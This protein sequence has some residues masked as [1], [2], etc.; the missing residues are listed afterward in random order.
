[1]SDEILQG[2]FPEI[3]DF[4]LQ[5]VQPTGETGKVVYLRLHLLTPDDRSADSE[6]VAGLALAKR[7]GQSLS[8]L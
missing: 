7:L 5:L 6:C 3:T 8:T 4:D 2:P 1:M